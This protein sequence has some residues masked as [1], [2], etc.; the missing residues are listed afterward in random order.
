MERAKFWSRVGHWFAGSGR[1][2]ASA[3]ADQEGPGL[4]PEVVRSLLNVLGPG[5]VSLE[6]VHEMAA[7]IEIGDLHNAPVPL[8]EETV[9]W[10]ADAGS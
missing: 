5:R 3:A 7:Q 6:Q 2:E 8:H 4:D 10:L 1:A 9:R